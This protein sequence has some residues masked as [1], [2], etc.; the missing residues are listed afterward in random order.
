MDFET[1]KSNFDNGLWTKV[2]V[3]V[4]VKKGIISKSQYAEITGEDY[5]NGKPVLTEEET[6]NKNE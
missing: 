5:T 6:D 1:I 4:A 2:L 3:K